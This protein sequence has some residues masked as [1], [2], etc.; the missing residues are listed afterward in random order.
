[1]DLYLPLIVQ[2]LNLIEKYMPTYVYISQNQI[3]CGK[4][5]YLLKGTKVT[6]QYHIPKC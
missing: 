2:I 1:M 5:T 6:V 3:I 4:I